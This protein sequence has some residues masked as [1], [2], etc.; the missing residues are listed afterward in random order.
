MK[1]KKTIRKL[2]LKSNIQFQTKTIQICENFMKNCARVSERLSKIYTQLYN[3]FN[4]MESFKRRPYQWKKDMHFCAIGWLLK[5]YFSITNVDN[6]MLYASTWSVPKNFC[7][8][9]YCSI[10]ETIGF[11]FKSW[12]VVKREFLVLLNIA[13]WSKKNKLNKECFDCSNFISTWILR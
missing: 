3:K 1:K 8:S 4:I 5:F 10:W 11:V 12:S 2:V 13:I 6:S 7:F 9:L